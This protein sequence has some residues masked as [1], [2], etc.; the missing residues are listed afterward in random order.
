[1]TKLPPDPAVAGA[2]AR[3]AEAPAS[4]AA[5]A[6]AAAA[7]PYDAAHPVQVA[8]LA[9]AL[10][11]QL[12]PVHGLGDE[13]RLLLRYAALLHDIGILSGPKGHHKRSQQIILRASGLPFRGRR[14][15]MVAL[16]AR[17]HRKALPSMRHELYAALDRA[18]RRRVRVL[19]GLLRVADGLDVSHRR[20]IRSLACRVTA[21]RIVVTCRVAGAAAAERERGQEKADL[22]EKVF[23]HRVDIVLGRR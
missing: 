17:Y 13:E 15:H 20:A 18:D 16:V 3:I 6:P 2:Q 19:A 1:M 14:R 5:P 11:D 23:R 8:R 21:G 7:T 9:L 10:F 12:R 4:V 22:M